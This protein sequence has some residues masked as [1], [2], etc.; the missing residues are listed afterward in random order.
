MV[1]GLL[2][3]KGDEIRNMLKFK[4]KPT[5]LVSKNPRIVTLPD[6]PNH[7]NWLEVGEEKNRHGLKVAEI[8]YAPSFGHLYKVCWISEEELKKA[9][10]GEKYTWQTMGFSGHSAP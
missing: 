2:E 3:E 1:D 8:A 4:I 7:M 5:Q 9:E 10:K 6:G